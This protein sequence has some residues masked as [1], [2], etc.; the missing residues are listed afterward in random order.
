MYAGIRYW[1]YEGAPREQPIDG[2]PPRD[3]APVAP[4][5]PLGSEGRREAFDPDRRVTAV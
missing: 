1:W 4:R 5:E 2:P 3:D